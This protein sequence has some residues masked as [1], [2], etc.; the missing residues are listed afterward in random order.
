MTCG[1][2]ENTTESTLAWGWGGQ[3]TWHLPSLPPSAGAALS[4]DD[5]RT[6]GAL[7]L[8]QAEKEEFGCPPKSLQ[9]CP[10]APDCL[11][12]PQC[13]ELFS[14]NEQRRYG[15]CGP[16]NHQQRQPSLSDA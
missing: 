8:L 11:P 4:P 1:H 6:A 14:T 16:Q 12:H 3:E 15:V 9:I 5:D 13:S 2:G 7:L 10:P